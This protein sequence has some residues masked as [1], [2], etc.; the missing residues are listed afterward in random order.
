MKSIANLIQLTKKDKV[1]SQS[2][3]AANTTS[4]TGGMG[5]GVEW[6]ST[7]VENDTNKGDV[8]A[9]LMRL[10]GKALD[11]W[12][13]MYHMQNLPKR[14]IF[15]QALSILNTVDAIIFTNEGGE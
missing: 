13:E 8:S 2:D 4:I 6:C 9:D 12:A 5:T 10:I 11:E 15:Q 14:I 3:G 7:P 1:Y